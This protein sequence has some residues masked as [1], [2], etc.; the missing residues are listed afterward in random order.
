MS[1]VCQ[2]CNQAKATVHITDTVPEKREQHLCEECAEKAGVIIKQ[3]HQTTNAILQEFIEHKTCMVGVD[4]R[5]CPECGIT[6]R[7]FRLK[8]QLGCPHD[9]EAFRSLLAPL[10]ERAHEGATQHVGKV[11]AAAGPAVQKQ[12]SLLR[13]QRELQDAVDREDYEQAASLRDRIQSFESS[14]S[15]CDP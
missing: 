3:Q 14:E 2:N 13:L 6:F 5:T 8:G 11:P 10:I 12:T 4:D 1:Y 9:Y 15:A 7:E